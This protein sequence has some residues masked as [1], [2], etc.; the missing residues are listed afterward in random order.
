MVRFDEQKA[1]ELHKQGLYDA[2]IAKAVGASKTSVCYWRKRRGLES[3]FKVKR[4]EKPVSKLVLDAKAA[5]AAGMTYGAWKTLG[6]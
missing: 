5:R 4:P 2:E 1:L 6:N 3:N